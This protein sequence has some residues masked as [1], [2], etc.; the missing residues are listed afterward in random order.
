MAKPGDSNHQGRIALDIH[1]GGTSTSTSKWLAYNTSRFGF[2]RTVP[3][4][5]W[6]WEYRP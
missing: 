3:S 6:P 5:P 1:V 2:T 4:E